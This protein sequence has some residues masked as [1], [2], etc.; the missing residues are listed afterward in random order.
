MEKL[1][2]MSKERFE[3]HLILTL[4]EKGIDARKMNYKITPVLY[5]KGKKYNSQDDFIRLW[6]LDPDKLSKKVFD[7]ETVVKV[8]SVVNP[9]YPMWINVYVRD[10]ETV[11]LETTIRFR[12]PSE[13][14]RVETGHPPFKLME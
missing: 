4:Q 14:Q 3:H 5:E 9:H 12:R 10:E 6:V 13:L 7:L 11:E 2:Q 1:R 8:F